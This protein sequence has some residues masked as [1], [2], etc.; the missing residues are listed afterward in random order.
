[1]AQIKK[2]VRKSPKVRKYATVKTARAVWKKEMKR[3]YPDFTTSKWAQSQWRHNHP[4]PP[5]IF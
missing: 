2:I 3:L 5:T 4:Q 1:M